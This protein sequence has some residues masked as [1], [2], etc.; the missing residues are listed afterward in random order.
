MKTLSK[1]L[2]MP[3]MARKIWDIPPPP[4]IPFLIIIFN[5][6][7]AQILMLFAVMEWFLLCICE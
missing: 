3:A 1:K 6:C 4:K 2:S 7:A 5:A